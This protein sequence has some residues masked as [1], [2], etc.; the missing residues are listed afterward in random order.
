MAYIAIAFIVMAYIVIDYVVMAYIP[1]RDRGKNGH[2]GPY[3]QVMPDRP[4]PM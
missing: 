2:S 1:R 3:S 4:W